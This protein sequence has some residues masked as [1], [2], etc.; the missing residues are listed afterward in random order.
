MSHAQKVRNATEFFQYS[1][2]TDFT[3][4][5]GRPTENLTNTKLVHRLLFNYWSKNDVAVY[6]TTAV[7]T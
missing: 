5:I 1:A 4:R 3:L 6:Y 7:S 2:T